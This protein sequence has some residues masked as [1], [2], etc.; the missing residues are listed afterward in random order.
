MRAV[1]LHADPKVN[2]NDYVKQDRL[3]VGGYGLFSFKEKKSIHA[4]RLKKFCFKV[5]VYELNYQ[6]QPWL[7]TGDLGSTLWMEL[8]CSLILF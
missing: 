5:Y 8:L 2:Y 3:S 4:V 6:C 1:P 7:A